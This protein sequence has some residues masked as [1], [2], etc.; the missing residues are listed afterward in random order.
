[1][2]AHGLYIGYRL[3]RSL[4]EVRRLNMV[5]SSWITRLGFRARCSKGGRDASRE[6]KTGE[7]KGCVSR[8]SGSP[9]STT[10][11]CK[12][13]TS[14]PP[15]QLLH[16]TISKVLLPQDQAQRHD[17]GLNIHFPKRMS[18]NST[19]L[20]TTSSSLFTANMKETLPDLT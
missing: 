12:M 11:A 17:S 3:K 5:N 6:L 4:F 8:I 1:M 18:S 10:M 13:R 15:T 20:N 2:T 9:T 14:V 7:I 16:N 19:S